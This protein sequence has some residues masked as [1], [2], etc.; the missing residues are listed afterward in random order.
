M[1]RKY[2]PIS[3]IHWQIISSTFI[4]NM[5]MKMSS[6]F[7]IILY[8]FYYCMQLS[9][10]SND[11]KSSWKSNRMLTKL[12]PSMIVFK[13]TDISWRVIKHTVEGWAPAKHTI[14]RFYPRYFFN[15]WKHIKCRIVRR[16]ITW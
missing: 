3:N 7:N 6:Y 16:K 9:K 10:Y 1:A 12:T 8:I 13:H 2:L 5:T 4:H 11:Y 15:I 14:S